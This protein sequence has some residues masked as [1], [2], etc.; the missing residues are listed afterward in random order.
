MPDIF[1][2]KWKHFKGD[3][4][5]VCLQCGYRWP[6]QDMNTV[7]DTPGCPQCGYANA[8]IL[9]ESH[10]KDWRYD[11]RL[12][13]AMIEIEVFGT[14][15]DGIP[16][17][18]LKEQIDNFLKVLINA[19]L[20]TASRLSGAPAS[21]YKDS[22]VTG[23]DALDSDLADRVRDF[24]DGVRSWPSDRASR[25]KRAHVNHWDADQHRN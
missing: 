12:Q 9:T 13:S 21:E 19:D 14:V 5:R 8:D 6:I 15:V 20:D 25:A 18:W 10:S 7:T 11:E 2:D 16:L 23:L 22:T 17:G 24:L 1:D 4:T 3:T